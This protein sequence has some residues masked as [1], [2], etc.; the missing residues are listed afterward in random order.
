MKLNKLVPIVTTDRISEVKAFYTAHLGFSVSFEM[1][2]KHL[3]IN[4]GKNPEIE[5]SFMAPESSNESSFSGKGLMYCLAVDDVD[6]EHQRL[7]KA[8]LDI[9]KQLRDNLWGDR[10]FVIADPVGIEIYIYS[11]IEPSKE[12]KQYYQEN[13]E[14][15]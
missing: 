6:F 11:L 13:Y 14:T 2:E 8:G 12:F 10:S 3:S 15:S 1:G 4:S 9:V 7:K 5:I